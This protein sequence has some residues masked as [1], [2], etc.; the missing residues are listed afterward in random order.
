MA[1]SQNKDKD[2]V[3]FSV[4]VR[5][6]EGD[7]PQKGRVELEKVLQT[8]ANKSKGQPNCKVLSVSK[9]GRAMIRIKPVTGA[10]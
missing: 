2:E 10:V 1:S 8:W 3:T 5:W 4:S 6:P 9:E 7:Q